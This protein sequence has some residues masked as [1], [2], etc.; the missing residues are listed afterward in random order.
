MAVVAAT[1]TTAIVFLPLIVGEKTELQ[2]WLGEVG[3]AITLTIFCSLLV[4]LTL[5]PLMG[6]R[7]LSRRPWHNPRWIVW[8]TDRYEAVINW[9]LR[10]RVLTFGATLLVLASIAGP[11]HAGPRNGDGHGRPE[12]PHPR[13]LRLPGLPL[14]GGRRGVVTRVEDALYAPR[15]GHRLRIGLLVLRRE[16][17]ADDH[18]AQPE[19]HERP[20][21]P[22]VPQDDAGVA[23]RGAR[24]PSAF[25][26]GGRRGG[27]QHDDASQSACSATT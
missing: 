25:R 17:G 4:S 12:R 23:A 10:H 8:L 18:H 27:R 26:R 7:I 14:Q 2:I 19:G 22:G 21:G 15:A 9:T 11:V 13:P 20:R 6:S 16:R 24:R 5:I 3:I 1:T